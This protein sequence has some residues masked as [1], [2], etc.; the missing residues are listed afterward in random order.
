MPRPVGSTPSQQ[1][2]VLSKRT[3][4]VHGYGRHYSQFQNKCLCRGWRGVRKTLYVV[5]TWCIFDQIT[6]GPT[7]GIWTGPGTGVRCSGHTSVGLWTWDYESTNPR[8]VGP[9]SE[10]LL[11]VC[12]LG[13]S[14]DKETSLGRL[15]RWSAEL[16]QP[17]L[18][19]F[20]ALNLLFASPQGLGVERGPE[21]WRTC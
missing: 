8:C 12:A 5:G 7:R 18:L 13:A 6:N 4:I 3:S 15:Q 14:L 21:R 19:E 17:C 1:H 20:C 9:E 2:L 10:C 11:A 16:T